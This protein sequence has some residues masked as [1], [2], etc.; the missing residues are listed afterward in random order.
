MQDSDLN[1]LRSF[2]AAGQHPREARTD[3]LASLNIPHVEGCSDLPAD[4]RQRLSNPCE[5]N[6][7]RSRQDKEKTSFAGS[8]GGSN[9]VFSQAAF[10]SSASSLQA[11]VGS[12]AFREGS[13]KAAS[14]SGRVVGTVTVF[15]AAWACTM[16]LSRAC[17]SAKK[18]EVPST[19]K[20]LRPA[21]H[22]PL[23]AP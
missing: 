22:T 5:R 20:A 13:G 2:L 9:L 15:A 23:C 8:L 3:T 7:P 16:S 4:E 6:R 12:L 18:C 11:V 19:L 10:S 17:E 1:F 21:S 14:F